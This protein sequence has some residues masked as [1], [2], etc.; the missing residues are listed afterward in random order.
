MSAF[1]GQFPP[2]RPGFTATWQVCSLPLPSSVPGQ[3]AIHF[4]PS[5]PEICSVAEESLRERAHLGRGPVRAPPGWVPCPDRAPSSGELGLLTQ[6][7]QY[8]SRWFD[9]KKDLYARTAL[10]DFPLQLLSYR[11]PALAIGG[12]GS[13][14]RR[15]V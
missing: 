10:N 5:P 9:Q 3:K 4:F 6:Q 15:G 1:L 7:W 14:S 2:P 13:T 8:L 12:H 11:E